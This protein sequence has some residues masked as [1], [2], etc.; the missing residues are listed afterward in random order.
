MNSSNEWLFSLLMSVGR[1]LP[2]FIVWFIGL[3]IALVR[4]P[5]CPAVSLLVFVAILVAGF[6]SIATQVF[7]TLFP[8]I[9]D[10]MNF[11]RIAGIVGFASTFVHACAWAC[12]LGA[13]FMG[14]GSAPVSASHSGATKPATDKP[15]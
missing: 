12:M 6:A 8:R 13:A 1:M 4:W 5:R 7:Y 11:A 15:L 2:M 14:R 9:G 3:V 10:T